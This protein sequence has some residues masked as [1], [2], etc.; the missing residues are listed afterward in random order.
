MLELL[1]LLIVIW[2]IF[3]SIGSGWGPYPRGGLL[4]VVLVLILLWFIFGHHHPN[5]YY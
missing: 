1:I 3:G 2:L 5:W 4:T